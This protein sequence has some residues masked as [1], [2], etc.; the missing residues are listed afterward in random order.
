MNEPEPPAFSPSDA[1]RRVTAMGVLANAV[2]LWSY[3]RARFEAE[4]PTR[5]AEAALN[6][7][8]V[9]E[10]TFADWLDD[11]V[12]TAETQ[13]DRLTRALNQRRTGK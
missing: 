7:L 12:D 10:A 6:A 13:R 11:F 8:P 5:F 9:D 2:T 1:L 3:L 4:H